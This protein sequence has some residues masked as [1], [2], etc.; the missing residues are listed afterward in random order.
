[1]YSILY[2]EESWCFKKY[3]IGNVANGTYTIA[4]S[5]IGYDKYN[6]EITVNGNLKLNIIIKENAE[7]LDEIIVTGVANPRSK[8]KSSLSISTIRPEVV[9]QSVPRSTAKI[10]RT[11]PGIRAESKPPPKLPIFCSKK[12][13]G[14]S[15]T[16]VNPIE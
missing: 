14:S 1:M 8:I 6:K 5:Y 9:E 2:K 13:S 12:L 3:G 11:I 4:A 10:F 7:S 15:L 16:L